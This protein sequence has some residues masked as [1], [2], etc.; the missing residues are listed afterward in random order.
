[1]KKY[2]QKSAPSDKEP[3][4]K[5][6]K[7]MTPENYVLYLLSRREYS[8]KEIRQKLKLREVTTEEIDTVLEKMT[9]LG[10]Q[11][12]QRFLES[13]VRLQKSSGKGPGYLRAELAQHQLSSEKIQAELD[14]EEHNWTDEAFH[15][16][17]RKFG[18][19][20]FSV[21]IQ[22]KAFALLLRRGF[23]YDLA[24]KATTQKR[25]EFEDE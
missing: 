5:E 15:L 19:P 13:R 11:S 6:S 8:Q 24:K 25:S 17:E 3:V 14:S 4:S 9:E 23:S 12:D 21:E 2:R 10:L 1:M 22:R 18:E 16:I 20:P 7:R